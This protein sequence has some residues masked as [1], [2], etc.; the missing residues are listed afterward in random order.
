[1]DQ[2][3]GI[4]KNGKLPWHLPSDMKFFKDVT[5]RSL[6]GHRN[7]VIMGRVT[8]DSI[9]EAFRPLR[10]RLNVILTRNSQIS[11]P[12]GCYKVKNL[13]EA[14]TC[15]AEIPDVDQIFV[16]GGATV[17]D[18]AIRRPE[19]RRLYVTRIQEICDCD[20]YFPS[21]S[22]HFYQDFQGPLYCENNHHFVFSEYTRIDFNKI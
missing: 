17:Y 7:A 14:L 16:I 5:M 8:W 6:S 3:Q 4:G 21:F 19:C 22:D 13:D 15:A 11:F 9:P 10:G 1:M 2:N 18:E 20:V 12:E